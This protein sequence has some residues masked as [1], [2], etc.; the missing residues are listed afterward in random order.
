MLARYAIQ[1]DRLPDP[2]ER[3]IRQPRVRMRIAHL[4]RDDERLADREPAGRRLIWIDRVRGR[5]ADAFQV[6][7]PEELDADLVDVPRTAS[8]AEAH[9][10]LAPVEVAVDDDVRSAEDV[11]PR[12]VIGMREK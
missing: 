11:H 9:D 10:V 2:F 7:C 1:P 8:I 12:E 4:R 3:L 6:G 5:H